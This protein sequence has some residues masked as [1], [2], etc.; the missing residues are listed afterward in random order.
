MK[1]NIIVVGVGTESHLVGKAIAHLGAENVIVVDAEK[2]KEQLPFPKSEPFII[3]A[4]H[5]MINPYG[6]KEFVCKG[7]H[8]YRLVDTVKKEMGNGT[9]VTEIWKCQC[10]KILGS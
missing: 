7:R 8:E 3:Q 9:L 10:G 4:P 5:P 6:G 2:T 1:E